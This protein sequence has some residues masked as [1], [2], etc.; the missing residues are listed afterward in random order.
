MWKQRGF[1]VTCTLP[2]SKIEMDTVL[3]NKTNKILYALKQNKG[4]LNYQITF[5][6]GSKVKGQC[7]SIINYNFF[8]RI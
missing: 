1:F 2:K 5:E 6:D 8:N 3:P 7:D 4:V